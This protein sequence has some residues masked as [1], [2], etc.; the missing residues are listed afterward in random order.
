MIEAQLFAALSALAGGRVFLLVAQHGTEAPYLVFSVPTNQ[1]DD[2]LAGL[3][4][5]RAAVQ[6]DAYADSLLAAKGLLADAL[7][8]VD[9]MDPGDL[10]ELQDY[11]PDTGLYRATAEVA[12]WT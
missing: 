12:I 6:L 5:K 8:A 9:H 2:A 1:G 3:G 11:E 7:G 4:A 10:M